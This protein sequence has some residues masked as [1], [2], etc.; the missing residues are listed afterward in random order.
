ML[1]NSLDPKALPIESTTESS[2]NFYLRSNYFEKEKVNLINDCGV[3]SNIGVDKIYPNGLRFGDNK[4]GKRSIDDIS[5]KKS[6]SN[7]TLENDKLICSICGDLASGYHYN[8]LSCEGCKGFFRRTVQRLKN[9]EQIADGDNSEASLKIKNSNLK[10]TNCKFSGNCEIDIYMR[11]KCPACRLKK[12][13]QVGMREECLLT[14]IQCQSKR[15][16]KQESKSNQKTK[17]DPKNP[18]TTINQ[19][20][21]NA[22]RLAQLNAARIQTEEINRQALIQQTM[23][24]QQ[25]MLLKYEIEQQ[26]NQLYQNNL[27]QFNNYLG[28]NSDLYN[29]TNLHQI[30]SNSTAS[31]QNQIN[32]LPTTSTFESLPKTEPLISGTL[33]AVCDDIGIPEDE[34]LIQNLDSNHSNEYIIKLK[35]HGQK[36]LEAYKQ[37]N[38]PLESPESFN[39]N[40]KASISLKLPGTIHADAY[41]SFAQKLPYFAQNFQL[42]EKIA[43][44]KGGAIEGMILKAAHF[45]SINTSA[46]MSR[47][48]R[49]DIDLDRIHNMI[50]FFKKVSKMKLN[51]NIFSLLQSLIIFNPYRDFKDFID[52]NKVINVRRELFLALKYGC[53]QIVD[54][55]ECEDVN[56]LFKQLRKLLSELNH[57]Q[58]EY[59]TVL[60]KNRRGEKSLTPLLCEIWNLSQANEEVKNEINGTFIEIP[61]ANLT[62]TDSHQNPPKIEEDLDVGC[63]NDYENLEKIKFEI[64]K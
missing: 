6:S 53:Q 4:F 60:T 9:M 27:N 29:F 59:N 11:R 58:K 8:A 32:L 55:T 49:I 30:Q 46:F 33:L 40:L 10:F 16:R 62:V 43:L 2:K 50:S 52:G 19:Y 34:K 38:I 17:I 12:C 61:H 41:V 26:V 36:I 31:N 18:F 47:M 37:Y 54:S 35:D 44:I 39:I 22:A 57:M 45:Y 20:Q 15:R 56:E 25:Q 64:I 51:E 3:G 1:N 23:T 7:G 42:I 5:L 28:L 13:R 63:N 48:T 21:I 24:L 14:D